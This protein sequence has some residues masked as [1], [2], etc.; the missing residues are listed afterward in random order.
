MS[1]LRL[2]AFLATPL[3]PVF[4][5]A[6]E[7]RSV[8]I[9]AKRSARASNGCEERLGIWLHYAKARYQ[10]TYERLLDSG[11]QW[12]GRVVERL[13][14]HSQQLLR[15]TLLECVVDFRAVATTPESPPLRPAGSA[16]GE[17]T[18]AGGTGQEGT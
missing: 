16:R 11:K 10:A 5:S 12:C 2:P 1:R 8:K 3:R 4:G 14:A 7:T 9:W 6:A 15:F 13:R 18:E 17:M